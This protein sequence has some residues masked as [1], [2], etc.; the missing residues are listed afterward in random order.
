MSQIQYYPACDV[1]LLISGEYFYIYFRNNVVIM[2]FF[3]KNSR[4][5]N[6]DMKVAKII[7]KQECL[8]IF[9][10][11]AKFVPEQGQ[12]LLFEAKYVKHRVV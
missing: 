5:E 10:L 2:L 3:I 8:I 6:E 9:R 12:N 1:I 11:V 4:Y 7:S